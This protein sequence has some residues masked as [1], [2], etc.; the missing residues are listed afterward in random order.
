MTAALVLEHLDIGESG[1][2]VDAYVHALPADPAA[3]SPEVS[4]DQVAGAPDASEL[5]DVDVEQLA[6][7]T[8]LVAVGWLG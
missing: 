4:D 7:M 3:A 6:G 8:P 1:G 5:L 2:V